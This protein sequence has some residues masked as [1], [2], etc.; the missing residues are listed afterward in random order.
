MQLGGTE[1]VVYVQQPEQ[2]QG[3][4]GWM[5]GLLKGIAVVPGDRETVAGV[6]AKKDSEARSSTGEMAGV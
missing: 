1:K 2:G 3:S 5:R 4:E 6:D